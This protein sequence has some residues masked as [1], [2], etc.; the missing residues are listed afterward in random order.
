M[1][2][3]DPIEPYQRGLKERCWQGAD[4]LLPKQKLNVQ[5]CVYVVTSSSHSSSIKL[6]CVLQS[7]HPVVQNVATM[8]N[9]LPENSISRTMVFW[10]CFR[11]WHVLHCIGGISPSYIICFGILNYSMYIDSICIYIY[12]Y[13]YTYIQYV[14]VYVYNWLQLYICMYTN[15]PFLSRFY[16]ASPPGQFRL[17][18]PGKAFQQSAHLR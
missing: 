17:Q 14:C 2:V 10:L 13:I 8:S 3:L 4:W 12:M 1:S 16:P 6:K 7:F 18:R 11:K 15:I 5:L 9:T